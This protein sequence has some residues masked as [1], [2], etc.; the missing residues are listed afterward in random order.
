MN[1]PPHHL[2]LCPCL[3]VDPLSG[4]GLGGTGA[5]PGVHIEGSTGS[6]GGDDIVLVSL[7]VYPGVARPPAGAVATGIQGNARVVRQFN[8][9][10]T[11]ADQSPVRQQGTRPDASLSLSHNGGSRACIAGQ[12]PGLLCRGEDPVYPHGA[13]RPDI[14]YPEVVLGQAGQGGKPV[15][16]PGVNILVEASRFRTRRRRAYG[17][18]HIIAIDVGS[19][20]GI[21]R[22]QGVFPLEQV[23]EDLVYPPF[24]GMTGQKEALVP[25]GNPEAGADLCHQC[26]ENYGAESQDY[27]DQGQP[28]PSL[29]HSLTAC[30]H[31]TSS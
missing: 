5:L 21:A 28:L 18:A 7:S 27:E 6:A 20:D 17:D 10:H 19:R 9:I 24:G 29:V 15:G 31:P 22:R 3:G 26:R 11:A 2:G 1:A 23:P 16:C 4:N 13:P 8:G 12:C 25:P 14:V 30:S